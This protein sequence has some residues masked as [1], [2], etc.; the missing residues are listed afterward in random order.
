[1]GGTDL[2][3][4]IP[5]STAAKGSAALTTLANATEPAPGRRES[6]NDRCKIH[7][8]KIF[9]YDGVQQQTYRAR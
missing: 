5:M 3:M 4:M 2:A 7:E 8:Y 6:A 9:G 1:M